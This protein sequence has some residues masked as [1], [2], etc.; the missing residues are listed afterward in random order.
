MFKKIL[1]V[2]VA[3]GVGL[4]LFVVFN[5]SLQRAALMDLFAE[6]YETKNFN[7]V[8]RIVDY[9]VPVDKNKLYISDENYDNQNNIHVEVLTSLYARST[10]VSDKTVTVLEETLQLYVFN[11]SNYQAYKISSGDTH[12][13][14]VDFV[15]DDKTYSVKMVNDENS[16]LYPNI[17]FNEYISYYG[18]LTIPLYYSS[19]EGSSLKSIKVYADS[20][21]T[22]CLSLDFGEGLDL[23]KAINLYE[24][25]TD[26]THSLREYVVSY[27]DNI[28]AGNDSEVK[29]SLSKIND[30][31]KN[32]DDFMLQADRSILYSRPRYYG[33][34]IGM[35]VLY[36]VIVGFVGFFI[37][38]KKK[39]KIDKNRVAN[40]PPRDHARV[41]EGVSEE[42]E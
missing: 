33:W 27:N 16:E 6:T 10:T 38:R 22:A 28:K 42:K 41:I 40:I 23:E 25:T 3:L 31:V 17:N 4:L 26:G 32:S 12:D 5:S 21:E 18:F 36:L 11:F 35:L 15:I 1:F 13:A 37:F 39:P 34:M 24:T 30:L 2:I 9:V 20:E 29:N 8:E 7:S 19:F 14:H